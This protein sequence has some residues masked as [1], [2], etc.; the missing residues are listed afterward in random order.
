MAKPDRSICYLNSFERISF[1]WDLSCLSD[2]LELHMSLAQMCAELEGASEGRV[3]RA[4]NQ[5]HC[6]KSAFG[7]EA[8]EPYHRYYFEIKC[9]KG[10]NFKIG[11]AT[12]SAKQMPNSAFSD[13]DQGYAYFS[14]GTLRHNSKGSGSSYGEKFK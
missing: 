11:I 13:T 8:L 4:T 1:D 7:K 10:S 2:H 3:C 6:F 12:Q 14:T 5:E 9:I